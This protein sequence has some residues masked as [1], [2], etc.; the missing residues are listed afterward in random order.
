MNFHHSGFH[1]KY[2]LIGYPLA[3]SFSK[4]FFSEKFKKENIDAE[5]ENFEIDDIS[6]LP[7]IIRDNPGLS[8]LNVT[9]PYKEKVIKFLDEL[10][11]DAG[12]VG[13]VNTIKIIRSGEQVK[14]KGFNTDIRG[15]EKS[16]SPLLKSYHKKALVLGTGGASKAVRY[17]LDKLEINYISASIEELKE[18]E[19]KYEDIDKDMISRRLLVINA[20]PLGTYPQ[21]DKFPPIPYKY[22]TEKHLLFDLV[23]NPGVTAFMKKGKAQGATV[24]NGYEML[25]L[26][27][28]ASYEIWNDKSI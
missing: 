16:L 2:G 13:A 8:G 1:R 17:V 5:Y 18:N 10:N 12:L 6:L 26:Q 25:V 11:E 20:T 19:I 3:H 14:L 23:Y 7:G 15:F 9:I 21:V 4:S 27:A 24:K 22:L 28:L